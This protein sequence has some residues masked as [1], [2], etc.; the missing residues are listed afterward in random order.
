[1]QFCPICS[2]PMKNGKCTLCGHRT[3]PELGI[4]PTVVKVPKKKV[5]YIKKH[6]NIQKA[7]IVDDMEVLVCGLAYGHSGFAQATRNIALYLDRLGCMVKLSP[8]DL[9]ERANLGDGIMRKRLDKLCEN[10]LR[11]YA[12]FK[13][14]MTVPM[15]IKPTPGYYN[16]A[17]AMFETQELPQ[18][19]VSHL[20]GMDELW[21]PSRFNYKQFRDAGYTKPLKVMPLGVNTE[22]FDPNN[23]K[24]FIISNKEKFM[25]LSIMGFSERK[26]IDPLIQAYCEE[27]TSDEKVCLMIKAGWYEPSDAVAYIQDIISSKVKNKKIPKILYNFDIMPQK[28]LPKLYKT[29]DCFVLASR[30]EGW[31]L[32]Y[33]EAMSMKLPTIGTR[34]TSQVDFMNNKNS[35]LVKIKNY[36][37]EPRCSFVSPDYAGRTFAN[38][39]V[40]DLRR[41]MRYVF[42]NINSKKVKDIAEQ[43]R[44]DMIE[45]YDWKISIGKVKSRIQEISKGNV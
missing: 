38:P 1:M 34:C 18:Y 17:Y 4:S 40:K 44:K 41:K 29:A 42:D 35:F 15:G 20:E 16:I 10:E 39:D 22:E 36:Q 14:M 5:N 37:E 23:V 7:N 21:I 25:F 30:G 8:L 31:G 24:P 12:K 45:K 19:F 43:A 2:S 28:D 13:I 33:T 32:N 9:N 26:G 27:F 11:G 6:Y 3:K